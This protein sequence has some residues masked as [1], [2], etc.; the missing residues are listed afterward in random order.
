MAEFQVT[1][2]TKS[3]AI[4]WQEL[5]LVTVNSLNDEFKRTITYIMEN[6]VFEFFDN[7]THYYPPSEIK[8]I[9]LNKNLMKL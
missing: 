3:G 4:I 5:P 6:G 1:I 9:S 2:K 8:S 7:D